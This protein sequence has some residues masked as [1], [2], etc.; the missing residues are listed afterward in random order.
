[1]CRGKNIC[2]ELGTDSN[3]WSK[4]S[5]LPKP[6]WMNNEVDLFI[7]AVDAFKAGNKDLC[8]EIIDQIRTAE[9]TE[10]YIEHGQMSGR[11]RKL[12]LNIPPP[13]TIDI[14]LRDPIRSPAK[15]QKQVF[16][17]DSY[18]CRYCGGKLI[19]QEFLKTFIK[20]LNSPLFSRG[21]TN[22]NTHGIIHLTWP[23]ADHVIPWNKGGRTSLDNLVSSCAPC[24]YGK[25]G[26]TIEQLGLIDPLTRPAK[27]SD[28]DGLSV[29]IYQLK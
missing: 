17:R 24:N 4:E 15:L 8:L 27:I 21:E 14:S 6:E 10:W 18:H 19:S 25:D 13:E 28:W 3:T 1:M 9:I 11:H 29:K 7:R 26:Y 12:Q 5:P 2:S 22:L 20:S 23:V 16:E